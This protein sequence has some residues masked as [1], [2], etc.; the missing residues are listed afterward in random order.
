VATFAFTLSG[1]DAGVG[2]FAGVGVSEGDGLLGADGGE[3]WGGRDVAS[4]IDARRME[5]NVTIAR[6]MDTLAR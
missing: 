4:L 3:D 1:V 6:S 5:T 2:V